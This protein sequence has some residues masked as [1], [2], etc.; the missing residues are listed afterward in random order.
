M[1]TLIA[2]L[3]ALAACAAHAQTRPLYFYFHAEAAA[4]PTREFLRFM[5][6]EE[7]RQAVK[8]AGGIPPARF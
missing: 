6:S 1:K 7:G 3:I 2:A 8:S 5:Q 4:A